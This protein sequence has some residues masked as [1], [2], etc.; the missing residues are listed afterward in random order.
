PDAGFGTAGVSAVNATPD[1]RSSVIGLR[2]LGDGRYLALLLPFHSTPLPYSATAVFS[3]SGQLDGSY[4]SGGV[5]KYPALDPPTDARAFET[6]PDGKALIGGVTA[7]PT[8]PSTAV[9][10]RVHG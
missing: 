7:S 3:S 1:D 8:N 10:A 9:I 5:T 2:Q 4:G 6:L